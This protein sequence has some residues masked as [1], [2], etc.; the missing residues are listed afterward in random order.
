MVL[1]LEKKLKQCPLKC[2]FLNKDTCIK[3]MCTKQ[4]KAEYLLKCSEN[5]YSLC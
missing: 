3:W 2:V 4:F 1:I 5:Q